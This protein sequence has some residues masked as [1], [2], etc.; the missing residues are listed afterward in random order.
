MKHTVSKFDKNKQNNHDTLKIKQLDSHIFTHMH[1]HEPA[2]YY[3]PTNIR[4][5]S[6]TNSHAH[7][8]AHTRASAH[9]FRSNIQK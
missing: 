4:A 8:H 5:C 2:V 7:T 1:E 6:Y 3:K 9:L